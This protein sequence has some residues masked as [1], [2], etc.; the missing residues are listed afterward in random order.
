MYD[1]FHIYCSKYYVLFISW[2]NSVPCHRTE[3]FFNPVIPSIFQY[4]TKFPKCCSLQLHIFWQTNK[5]SNPHIPLGPGIFNPGFKPQH[6]LC[7]WNRI[8][9]HGISAIS[10]K[11]VSLFV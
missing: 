8:V 7:S 11:R 2:E 6:I 1:S 3:L 5:D 4:S 10:R 9:R